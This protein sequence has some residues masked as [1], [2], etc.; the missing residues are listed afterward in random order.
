MNII[1]HICVNSIGIWLLL[2]S[3]IFSKKIMTTD[4]VYVGNKQ[5][6][7]RHNLKFHRKAHPHRRPIQSVVKTYF[8][9]SINAVK[10]FSTDTVNSSIDVGV[11]PE[12]FLN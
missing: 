7:I 6:C 3:N 11:F 5:E 9:L 2:L 10:K 12:D 4:N 8:S 1:K